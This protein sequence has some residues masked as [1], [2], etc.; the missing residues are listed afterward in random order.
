MGSNWQTVKL[1]D[2]VN[3]N[4]G[5]LNS[6]A[7]VDGGQYPF[8]TCS[9][10]T[11]RINTHAFDCEAVLLAGN[12]ANGVFPVK[13]YDGRFNAY[14]RT[15]VITPKANIE[16][17]VKWLFFQIQHVT[18]VLQNLSVGTATKFLTKQILDSFEVKL[19]PFEHQKKIS[20]HLWSL[21]EK[22]NLNRQI[23]Q[24]LEQMAQT[25]FKSWFVDFDPVIDNA[26]DAGFFEQ[27]LDLPDGLLRRAEVRRAVRERGDFKPLPDATRQLFP[28]AFEECAEPSLGLGGWVPQGWNA[29]SLENVTSLIIDHRGKTPKKLGGD[30]SE[31]GHPAISAKN[32]KNGRLVRHD[33]IRYVDS[34]LYTRWMKDPLLAGDI[35]MTSE[36]PLGELLYL[37]KS[38][39][40]LLSQRLYGIRADKDFISGCYLYFW[41][42]TNAARADIDGRATGT[43]VVGIRQ[44]ELKQIK[45]MVPQKNVLDEFSNL[46]SNCL[47]KIESN[48]KQCIELE[49]I[50]DEL[51]PQLISGKLR[52]DNIEADLAKE[53]VA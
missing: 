39:D 40:Y 12:N 32:I 25:L 47:E 22:E 16:L 14:Q 41:L 29:E 8:F 19:P 49:K 45:V 5:K 6:N 15:Y 23:N 42:Q 20:N 36:A 51:L 2:I 18:K 28:A 48:E 53:G 24:T 33:T 7:A 37:V 46:V 4:T 13:Y 11:L 44:S 21:L 34:S 31:R 27:E 1:K 26:L 9:P 50:R 52:L 30:W 17:D 3:F 38:H 10:E 35:L 43:T